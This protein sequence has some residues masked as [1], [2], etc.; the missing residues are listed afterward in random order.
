MTEPDPEIETAAILNIHGFLLEMAFA[1]ICELRPE[2][3]QE[4]FR[5]IE[6]FLLGMLERSLANPDATTARD[7]KSPTKPSAN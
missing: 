7:V 6:T 1:F 2:G 5:I 3:P 4:A